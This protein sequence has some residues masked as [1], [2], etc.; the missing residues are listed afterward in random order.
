M[1]FGGVIHDGE[2]VERLVSDG[3]VVTLT[4]SKSTYNARNVVLAAGPWTSRLTEPLGLRLPLEVCALPRPVVVVVVY[5]FQQANKTCNNNIT[6]NKA[7][8]PEGQMPIMLA[9]YSTNKIIVLKR[10]ASERRRKNEINI[11]QSKT[12]T[13]TNSQTKKC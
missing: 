10:Y 8:Q 2:T 1:K 3:D 6:L 9:T 13:Q 7:R 12:R 5:L 11:N 4:T